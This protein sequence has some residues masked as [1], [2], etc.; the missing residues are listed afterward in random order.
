MK[1]CPYCGKEYPDEATNCAIDNE[2]L[3]DKPPQLATAEKQEIEAAPKK[4]ES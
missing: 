3:L 2:L 1:K 4:D